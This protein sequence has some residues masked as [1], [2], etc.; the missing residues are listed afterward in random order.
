[1]VVDKGL[2]AGETVVT[3]GQLRLAPD[4]RVAVRG[5]GRGPG[6]G[7]G[8]AEETPSGFGRKGG[9]GRGAPDTK[10]G[11]SSGPG[12]RPEV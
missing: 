7:R 12:N 11:A 3:E 10:G 8:G 9:D 5:G 4:S 1:M 2:A 6:G